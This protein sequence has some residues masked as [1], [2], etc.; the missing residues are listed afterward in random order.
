MYPQGCLLKIVLDTK[1]KVKSWLDE[2]ETGAKTEMIFPSHYIVV[3][4][5]S[6][7]RPVDV[8]AIDH[9]PSVLPR[10]SSET[11]ANKMTPYL[12]TLPGVSALKLSGLSIL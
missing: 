7:K 9:L 5:F 2:E 12:L 10:E 3:I 1:I 4:S 11:F 6:S 8:S